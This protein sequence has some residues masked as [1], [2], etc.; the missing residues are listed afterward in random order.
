MGLAGYYREFIRGYAK[1]AK[2]MTTLLQE[3]TPWAWSPACQA[4]FEALKE[5]L[6]TEP[7]LALPEP[8]RLFV[9]HC[10]FSH[11]ALG[12]VLEQLKE[13]NKYHII[14]CASRNCT[15]AEAKLGPTDGEVLALVFAVTK[16]HTYL[17]GA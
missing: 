5:K 9:V 8:D 2:P 17:A 13:D 14:S 10:D 6:S 11:V 16:F 7:I 3:D 12:A 1:I 4:A 15:S